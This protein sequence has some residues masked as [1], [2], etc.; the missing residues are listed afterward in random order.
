MTDDSKKKNIAIE[1]ARGTDALEEATS[2]SA[3][4]KVA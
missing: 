3:K 1:L 4:W 2:A